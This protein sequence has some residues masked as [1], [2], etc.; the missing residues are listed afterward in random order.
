[1][2]DKIF[3]QRLDKNEVLST[4]PERVIKEAKQTKQL[5]LFAEK[6][7]VETSFLPVVH[8]SRNNKNKSN[9]L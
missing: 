4:I 1:L 6:Q 3:S 8:S 2:F 7:L 5:K 9:S